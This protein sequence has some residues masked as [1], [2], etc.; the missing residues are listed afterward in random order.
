[1]TDNTPTPGE[2]YLMMPDLKYK[3]SGAV[4]ANADALKTPPRVIVKPQGGGIPPLKEK[5]II[6]IA[7]SG[8]LPPDLEG[9][10]SGYWLI[11]ERLQRVFADVDPEGFAFAECDVRMPDGSK[12]PAYYLCD[13]VRTIDALDEENSQLK[14]EIDDEFV[15]GKF[16]NIVGGESLA[17]RKKAIGQG[18]IFLTPYSGSSSP[19]CDRTLFDAVHDAGIRTG[20]KTDGI[21]FIDAATSEYV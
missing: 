12:G 14:I 13:V 4:F 21:W 7:K 10:Y 8:T 6:Q 1:M 19:F 9:G 15:N 11:S 20:K 16:Y 17:F 3:Y 5:P 2:F 18:H